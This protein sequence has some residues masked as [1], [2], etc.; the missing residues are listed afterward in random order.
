MKYSF[1]FTLFGSKVQMYSENETG[2]VIE[3]EPQ[4]VCVYGTDSNHQ[5]IL[6]A[7]P[8]CS[9]K[10]LRGAEYVVEFFENDLAKISVSDIQLIIDFKNQ[11]CKNNKNVRCYGSDRWG[12]DVG[13][14]WNTPIPIH[15]SDEK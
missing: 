4:V 5:N 15:L 7:I 13:V 1:K 2:I 12:Q 11:K 10:Y 3:K 6:C 14:D 8:L 9:P